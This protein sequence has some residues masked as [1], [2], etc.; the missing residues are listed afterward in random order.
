MRTTMRTELKGYNINGHSVA[1]TLDNVCGR[2][3]FVVT[4]DGADTFAG[5]DRGAAVDAL[6]KACAKAG[7]EASDA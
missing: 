6:D 7:K 3:F 5:L 4:V 1:L 2:S